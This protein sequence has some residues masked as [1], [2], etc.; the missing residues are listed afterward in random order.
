MTATRNGTGWDLASVTARGRVRPVDV[1]RS[2][3][4]KA[5]TLR[6]TWYTLPGLVIVGALLTLLFANAARRGQADPEA[7]PFEWVFRGL[8]ILQ[9]IAGYLGAR[10]VTVEYATGTLGGSLTA[11]PRRGR[12]LAAKAV[13]YAA[14]ALVAGWVTAVTMFLIGRTVLTARG[15]PFYA[16][17]DP[18]VARAL[19][20][21]GLYMAV[22]SLFGLAIGVLVRTTA[23]AVTVLFLVSL[24][25]PV[26]SQLYPA[27]LATFVVKYFPTTAGVRL[28]TVKD[29][30]ALLAPWPGFAV[31][32][33][34]TVVLLAVAYVVFRRR[35][36]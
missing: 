9:L 22:M 19:A 11:V 23:G 28:L 36:A 26:L 10:A 6:S 4:S 30:P 1:V 12:I 35:D 15:L 17:T 16:V 21:V 27:W 5:R 7:D 13:V 29:D 31:F 34:Y 18:G 32:C 24:L 2:E 25:I 14:M 33:A 3:W 20:G 8:L